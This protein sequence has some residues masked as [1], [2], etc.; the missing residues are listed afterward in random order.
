LA[1]AWPR[2]AK[3]AWPMLNKLR[4]YLRRHGQSPLR[5]TAIW[6]GLDEDATRQLLAFLIKKGEVE[7][8]PEGTLCEGCSACPP[9]TIEIYR[10]LGE[11]PSTQKSIPLRLSR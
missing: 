9:Q 11:R 2:G 5:E 8:L 1:C 7:K 10:W 3:T 4:D 6:L